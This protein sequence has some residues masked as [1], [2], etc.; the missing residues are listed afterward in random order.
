MGALG[1]E[2]LNG[3]VDDESDEG[4]VGVYVCDWVGGHSVRD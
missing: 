1:G 3:I 4:E 2:I